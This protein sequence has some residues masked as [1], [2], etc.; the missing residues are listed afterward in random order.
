MQE[1][2]FDGRRATG[3]RTADGV[4][5]FDAVV[6]NADFAQAMTKLVPNR[7]RRRWTD[8]KLARKKFS[9]STFM[10]YLG[11]EGDLG[12]LA[13]HTVLLAEDYRRNVREIE[14]GLVPPGAPSVYVQNACVTDPALAP[15]GHS[16]LYCLVP[17]GHQVDTGADGV[18]IDWAAEKPRYRA[19]ALKRLEMLGLRDI[20]RR[21]RFERITTPTN[22]EQDLDIYRGATFN[23]TH[24]LGQMLHRRPHNR[25]EDLDGMYLVGGGTHPGSG[26]PVIFESARITARLMVEDL[27][28]TPRWAPS[29]MAAPEYEPMLTEAL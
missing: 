9:C 20:E 11:I 2:L 1:I 6:V 12:D 5:R 16:T 25:F 27:G 19:L 21:I 4:E 22:W 10:L 14:E 28:L 18:G 3:L 8:S 26:L 24:S 15:R 23:L 7:L 13:H 29:A 17:V